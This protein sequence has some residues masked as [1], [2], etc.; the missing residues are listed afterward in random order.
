MT[1]SAPK[2]HIVMYSGGIGSWATARIVCDKFGPENVVLLMA[3]CHMED[4]DLYRF[5]KETS[6]KLGAKLVVVEDDKGR[7]PW[8]VFFDVRFLGNSRIDPCSQKLKRELLN[9]YIADNFKPEECVVYLGMDAD[10]SAR[11][12]RAAKR[13]SVYECRSVLVELGIG[14]ADA[15]RMLEAEGVAKP[16]LYDLGF[17]HNNCGGFCVK[18]GQKHFRN[19]LAKLPDVF[20]YHEQKEQEIRSYLGKDVS[21]L[22]VQ[23]DGVRRNFTLADLRAQVEAE[24]EAAVAEMNSVDCDAC[25]GI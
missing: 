21:I 11:W 1:A 4:A 23:K 2:T 13:W 5:V 25:E 14:R 7:D 8:K 9:K 18:A 12:E 3:D 10:E 24:N 6:A 20:K 16:R 17:S 15:F 22:R 19:L